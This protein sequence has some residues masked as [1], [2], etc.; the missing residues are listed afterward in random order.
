MENFSKRYN[1][2]YLVF[3]IVFFLFFSKSVVKS[4]DSYVFPDIAAPGMVT[5][6][7]IVAK[8]ND[9][10]FFGSDGFSL[11]NPSSNVSI[12]IT[13]QTPAGANLVQFGPISV[14]WTGRLLSSYVFVNPD[15]NPKDWDWEQSG[16]F[17]IFE[18]LV[19]G[20][21]V[22]EYRIDIVKPFPFGDKSLN[23]ESILGQGQL[24]RRSRR[25]AMIVDSM[26][27]GNKAYTVS[28]NDIDASLPGNQAYLPFT[29][30]S[31]GPIR[32][33]GANSEINVNASSLN[34]GVGGGGGAGSFCD[35]FFGASGNGTKGG[36]GFT[37]GGPGGQ[38]GTLGSP[39]ERKESGIGTG[40]MIEPNNVGGYSINGIKGGSSDLSYES[41]GGGTG[42]PFG[43]SGDGCNDGNNCNTAGGIGGGSGYR[44]VSVGGSAGH[45]TDGL[46]SGGAS[47]TGGKSYGNVMGVPLA[48]GSGGAGGNPQGAGCAGVGG[49]GGG[50]IRV[51]AMRIENVKILANGASG[52]NGSAPVING[53]AGSGGFIDFHSKLGFNTVSVEAKGGTNGGNGRV[54]FNTLSNVGVNPLFITPA[55]SNYN[56]FS[57]DSTTFLSQTKT[58][59]YG[60]AN[61]LDLQ[62]GR[63]NLY[64]KHGNRD[65]GGLGK[66]TAVGAFGK[67]EF[68]I[69]LTPYKADITNTDKYFYLAG[70]LDIS[71]PSTTQYKVEPRVVFSQSGANVLIAD[72]QPELLTEKRPTK[73]IVGCGDEVIIDS[74]WATNIGEGSLNV[75]LVNSW[76]NGNQGFSIVNLN[77]NGQI[78]INP[79]DS[80]RIKFAFDTKGKTNGIYRDSLLLYTNLKSNNGVRYLL[81]EIDYSKYALDITD[82]SNKS[83]DTLDLGT[84]CKGDV[85]K[86]SIKLVNKSGGNITL[87]PAKLSVNLSES[88]FT[89]GN[90]V[91]NG[92]QTIELQIPNTNFTTA[93]DG[94]V[95]V[96]SVFNDKCTD[97]L[98]SVIVKLVISETKLSL[99]DAADLDFGDVI[100]GK[101]KTQTIRIKNDGPSDAYLDAN[102]SIAAPYSV[103]TTRPILPVTLKKDEIIEVDVTF[104]PTATGRFDLPSIISSTNNGSGNN[105]ACSG[106]LELPITGVGVNSNFEY[107]K[108]LDF[109]N[110]LVCSP[111]KDSV[112]T[113]K[114]KNNKKVKF[115]SITNEGNDP[116]LFSAV[117][118]SDPNKEYGLDEEMQFRVTFN[119]NSQPLGFKSALANF[120]IT[121]VEDA[122]TTVLSI[123]YRGTIEGLETITIPNNQLDF[124]DIAMGVT[125]GPRKVKIKNTGKLTRTYSFTN[126]DPEIT[127]T[128]SNFT[129]IPDEEIDLDVSV[130]VKTEGVFTKNATIKENDCNLTFDLVIIGK[131]IASEVAISPMNLDFGI[132]SPCMTETQDVTITNNGQIGV[133]FVKAEIVGT[134]A[135]FFSIVNVVSNITLA[136]SSNMNQTIEFTNPAK[137]LGTFT[138]ELKITM[139][140]NG[141][142]I[143]YTIPLSVEVNTGFEASPIAPDSLK[144]E[145]VVLLQSLT[146]PF[147]FKATEKWRIE[148][149]RIEVNSI[150]PNF[151]SVFQI[152]DQNL[153]T[154]DLAG[155]NNYNWNLT[156]APTTLD[157][158][159]GEIRVF[160]KINSDNNCE[161]EVLL[162]VLGYGVP[163]AKVSISID[164]MTIDPTN[165]NIK[166]P[167][168][169]YIS[170]GLENIDT[171]KIDTLAISYNYTQFYPKSVENGTIINSEITDLANNRATTYITS[172]VFNL[173]KI[174]KDVI[175]LVG[176]PMLGNIVKDSVKIEYAKF[177]NETLIGE[178]IISN[179]SIET[180]VCTEGDEVRLLTNSTPMKLSIESNNDIVRLNCQTIELGNQSLDIYSLT[181]ELVYSNK[182][183]YR[184]G[185]NS[186][187]SFDIDKNKFSSG[188][189]I[190]KFSSTNRFKILKISILR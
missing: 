1:Q 42:H 150:N 152:N 139:L 140:E 119:S 106:D 134:N 26:V 146:K 145:N 171:M 156:F 93:T 142:E 7:E 89:I 55:G 14:S 35:V 54:R 169:M 18:V 136:D 66:P 32:G 164:D 15:V 153:I 3:F 61:L 29:L 23:A 105:I 4:Q 94:L 158:V 177:D 24:G 44:Q 19:G 138:A 10:S 122:S 189:Y 28:R 179:G 113:I 21:R 41:S 116:T 141:V 186:L 168:K 75:E 121:F 147:I 70:S 125:A 68:E 127:I 163:A 34:G 56:G 37:G 155:G 16:T 98:D 144:F 25:G 72:L 115:T 69:D 97:V 128:P 124:G 90:F 184:L 117:L 80:I 8:A 88:G 59:I 118:I 149:S 46:N 170:S 17:V 157:T 91:N 96:F 11:N 45:A 114:N 132:K 39:D 162:K 82:M 62:N 133:T 48:G 172:N 30:I 13:Q 103:I 166:I 86:G 9:N 176:T 185:M 190:V 84:I 101:A 2:Q 167:V 20:V 36:D 131:S 174:E 95:G 49:G 181:G 74:L 178:K 47:N 130:L 112:I 78:P 183:E 151:S 135:G 58:K 92:T 73:K 50:A 33:T 143:V 100:V 154:S 43:L 104:S 120:L 38:N 53:G 175:S 52:G 5:Y 109:G 77:P 12:R 159:Y 6:F 79:K 182:W 107:I 188:L 76:V 99:V 108:E 65:W 87:I 64:L 137:Q 40:E 67:W 173:D 160:Y 85:A 187:F 126:N 102:M 165:D 81:V 57:I 22:S 27:L 148:V 129:L 123:G 60:S 63:I 83:I 51:Q 110:V 180:K 161:E 71:S 111:N 31:K